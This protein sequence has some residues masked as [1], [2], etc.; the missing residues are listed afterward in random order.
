MSI[1]LISEFICK[2]IILFMSVIIIVNCIDY[3][4]KVSSSLCSNDDNDDNIK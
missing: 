4:I 3:T 2:T 1:I